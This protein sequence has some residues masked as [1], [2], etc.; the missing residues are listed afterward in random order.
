MSLSG[1]EEHEQGILDREARRKA[2]VEFGPTGK[3]KG[4]G[5]QVPS[6]KSREY[7]RVTQR[8]NALKSVKIVLHFKRNS[9]PKRCDIKSHLGLVAVRQAEKRCGLNNK[10]MILMKD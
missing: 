10:W 6:V 8:I 7:D 5:V 3:G 1:L 4:G 9:Y 2:L